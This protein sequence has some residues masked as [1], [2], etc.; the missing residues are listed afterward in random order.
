MSTLL[1]VALAILL[2]LLMTR[3]VKPLKLPSVTAYLITGVLMGPYCLGAIGVSGLG[4]N[5]Q[6]AVEG[7]ELISKIAL[8]FIA[9]SIGNEFRLKSLKQIGKQAVVIGFAQALTATLLVDVALIG[10]HF[11]LGDKL[12]LPAAI[13]LGAIASATAPAATL[14]VVRQYKAK[15]K[16]TQLLLP[17]VALDDAI[18]LVVFAVSFGI[19][20]AMVSNSFDVISIVVNPIIEIVASLILGSIM[21]ALLTWLEKFFN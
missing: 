15:G 9:F 3:V 8:G 1:P 4:F 18:G 17:I 5:S 2:G 19:S 12:P 6:E 7:L 13:T 10:L 21:G 16:V 11:V 20:K 14:M